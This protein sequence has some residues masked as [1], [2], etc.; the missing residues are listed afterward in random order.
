MSHKSKLHPFD[1][2]PEFPW[3]TAPASD[4]PWRSA[5]LFLT[6]CRW[7]G[8]STPV[9]MVDPVSRQ[10]LR[11]DFRPPLDP[12]EAWRRFVAS[13]PTLPKVSD[14]AWPEAVTALTDDQILAVCAQHLVEARRLYA[15]LPRPGGTLAEAIERRDARQV[16]QHLARMECEG[17]ARVHLTTIR[18]LFSYMSA[19]SVDSDSPEAWDPVEPPPLPD[20]GH[21]DAANMVA[22][23]DD[24]GLL[25]FLG[26]C[27]RVRR[28]AAHAVRVVEAERAGC[29]DDPMAQFERR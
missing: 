7:C 12:E 13:A 4:A 19:D 29:L 20:L 3:E 23:L 16:E 26:R 8:A 24:R 22:F 9:R 14:P 21:P 18:L 6:N 5:L 2:A 15:E 25:T 28:H 11:T 17:Q 27:L 10:T 1:P